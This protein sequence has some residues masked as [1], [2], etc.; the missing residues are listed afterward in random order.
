MQW[1]LVLVLLA[2]VVLGW[3]WA[4]H[5]WRAERFE[6]ERRV[7]RLSRFNEDLRRALEN[8]LLRGRVVERDRQISRLSREL[9]RAKAT[10]EAAVTLAEDLHE[11]VRQL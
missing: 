11:E 5:G 1:L 8:E 4:W 6:L 7:E 3:V 10:A 9:A 2:P